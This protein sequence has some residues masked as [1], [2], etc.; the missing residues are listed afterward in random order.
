MAWR[1]PFT[2]FWNDPY[3]FFQR[4]WPSRY[5]GQGGQTTSLWSPQIESFQRGDQ[6]VVRADLP[7]LGKDDVAIELTETR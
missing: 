6:F 5:F 7:G 1:D 2:A 3:G 4:A